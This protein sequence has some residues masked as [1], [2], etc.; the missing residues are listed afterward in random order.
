M[1]P[2]ILRSLFL[3]S[4]ISFVS[5]I[6]QDEAF[7]TDYHYALLG[8]P[9]EQTTFFHRPQST[10]S[11]SLLYTLTEK[12]VV[13]A[14][15]PK[16]GSIIWRQRLNAERPD[17]TGFL[18]AGEDQ[19]TVISAIDGEVAAWDSLNGKAV[20]S[21]RFDDGIIKD[22][23][24]LPFDDRNSEKD[25]KGPIVLFGQEGRGI[26][27]RL[28]GTTGDVVW[29]YHDD[30][31]GDIPYQLSTTATSVYL[32]SLHG[33][34]TYKIRVTAIDPLTGK[35]QDRYTL[36]S[37][38]DISDLQSIHYVGANVASPI[39]AWTDKATKVLKI[40][41][42]GSKQVHTFKLSHDQGDEILHVSI[43]APHLINSLPHFLVHYQT[44]TSHW[45]EVYHID[46]AKST[47]TKAY[48]LPRVGG[49][50]T[51]STSNQDANV[52]F[53][54]I[55]ET[56]TV[57]VSSV[58]HGILERWPESSSIYKHGMK[59]MHAASE[60][61]VK[62]GSSYAVR[63]AVTLDTGDWVL[64]RNGVVAW[65]R[66]EA[67]SGAM[68]AEWADLGASEALTDE[69]EM[70]SHQSVLGA[71]VNRWRRH[72][73]DLRRLPGWLYQFGIRT[74]ESLL[75]R[76]NTRAVDSGLKA[77]SY[78][79]RKLVIVATENGRLYALDAGQHGKIVWAVTVV[80]GEKWAVKNIL[81]DIQKGQIKVKDSKGRVFIIDTMT[82]KILNQSSPSN[83]SSRIESIAV[84]NTPSGEKV[85]LDIYEDGT[86][87]DIPSSDPSLLNKTIIIRDPSTKGIKGIRF[88]NTKNTIQPVTAWEFHP[89]QSEFIAGYTSRPSHDPVASLGRVLGDRS[90]LYKYLNPNLL[91]IVTINRNS[92]TATFHIL[93][94]IT[95]RILQSF[96]QNGVDPTQDISLA[97]SENWFIWTFYS[98][99]ST[100]PNSPSPHRTT[101]GY[102]GYQIGVAEL[103]TSSIPND[104]GPLHPSN[105][106]TSGISSKPYISSSTF[107]I[108]EPIST[109]T[110]TQ[111]LQGITSRSILAYL[112][113]SNALMAIPKILLDP[114]RPSTRDPT[115]AEIEEGLSR[116]GPL[117]E[118]DPRW[119]LSHVRNVVGIKEVLSK[120]AGRMESTSLVFAYGGGG[121]VDAEGVG[122]GAG[123][124]G[125]RSGA[126][127][128]ADGGNEAGGT[129]RGIGGMAGLDLF[130]TLI[131]PSQPFDL[132]GSEFGKGQLLLTILALG[133]GV[134]LLRPRVRRKGVDGRWIS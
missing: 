67:L 32:L 38:S 81:P 61:V 119:I 51:F 48:N 20:W 83:K 118:F 85:L 98:E 14:V 108:P 120:P 50:G 36:S 113:R 127:A 91:I 19:D 18:R 111:T 49:K 114:R 17:S 21:N 122:V 134:V 131:S 1:T 112:P 69:L 71:Y 106:S 100:S 34:T 64:I 9:R 22:L 74:Q 77:D 42:I 87:G 70:E 5:S 72:I 78:G 92:M 24:V 89:S 107:F 103:Y 97:M 57:L 110:I 75:G 8:I 93:D 45:A 30:S 123:A 88:I 99:V 133:V 31:S 16:N 39:V 132:L 56:E 105:T 101:P 115:P 68:A 73:R 76:G 65:E 33:K 52:Y 63:T 66:P 40:N 124:A 13:G 43:H 130:G 95:G 60:V 47:V 96:T 11:A 55:T 29:E 125:A 3:L 27:R 94:S 6:F 37:D 26:V 4:F 15:N 86:L 102:R 41:I 53:V 104:R 58:S 79:F 90:V 2:I 23:E 46:L 80:D 82:G 117:L 128:K 35:Q 116:R 10:F 84:I 44:A 12:H 129:G 28:G 7:Q 54:R 59:P 109:L 126:T 62:P 121:E 25:V